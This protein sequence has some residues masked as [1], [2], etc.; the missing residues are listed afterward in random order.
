VALLQ[1]RLAAERP[2]RVPALHRAAAAW[3]AEHGLADDAVRHALAAGELTQAADLVERHFDA[4]YFTGESA[5][6]QRWLSALPGGLTRSRPRIALSRAFL[7][8]TAGDIDTAGPAVTALPADRVGADD[9]FR[10]SVGA[11][12]SFIV[13]VPAAAAIARAWLAFLRGDAED[14]AGFA[15]QAQARLRDGERTLASI[16]RLNLALADWLRGRL[17]AAGQQFTAAIAGWRGAGQSALAAQ[18]CNYLGQIRRAQGNLDTALDAYTELLQITAPPDGTR[19]PVA[20]IGHVG[21]AE[22]TYQ[23]GDLAA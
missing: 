23:R 13:N 10:P 20:G 4:V 15:A 22:V 7:A 17:G 19:S 11:A 14:M 6:V 5:T 9:S 8:L 3:H 12:G 18:G 21:I 16:V 2:D 1:G